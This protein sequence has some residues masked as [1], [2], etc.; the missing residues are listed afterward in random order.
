M[1][2]EELQLIQNMQVTFNEKSHAYINNDFENLTGVTGILHKYVFPDMYDGVSEKKLA[3]AA[4]RGTRIHK[5]CEAYDNGKNYGDIIAENAGYETQIQNYVNIVNDNKLTHVA[6]EYLISDNEFVASS[7]DKVYRASA[8]SFIIADIKTTYKLNEDYV[9]WQLSIYKYLFELQNPEAKVKSLYAIW[10][11]DEKC[12]FVELEPIDKEIVKDLLSC[13]KDGCEWTN[14]LA[15]ID[16]ELFDVDEEEL[17]MNLN[18]LKSAD[19]YKKGIVEQ[20]KQIFAEHDLTKSFVGKLV[21]IS[22]SL[23]GH[24]F[25]FNEAK[26]AEQYPELYKQFLEISYISPSIKI[27]V[28]K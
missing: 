16:E 18:L 5:A 6:S 22:Q 12:K 21:T 28:N 10:L 19:N 25:K 4:E 11:R 20:Y 9:R 15:R 17:L 14:P 23:P 7:I 1:A 13:A 26:F 27:T 2:K 8:K 24:K 3:E